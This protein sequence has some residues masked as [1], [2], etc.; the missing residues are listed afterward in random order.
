MAMTPRQIFFE[1]VQAFTIEV[2]QT[3]NTEVV[4]ATIADWLASVFTER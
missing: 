4:M 2:T 1:D 3:A